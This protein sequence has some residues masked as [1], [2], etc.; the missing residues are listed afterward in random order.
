MALKL[1]P[2][3]RPAQEVFDEF[4]EK[5]PSG[6]YLKLEYNLPHSPDPQPFILTGALEGVPVTCK[7]NGSSTIVIPTSETFPIH[8]QLVEGRNRISVRQSGNTDWSVEVAATNW[9][10]WLLALA[11]E[12]HE[13]ITG[14]LEELQSALLSP[15]GSRLSE[16][17][18][19]YREFLVDQRGKRLFY[20]RMAVNASHNGSGT[21]LGVENLSLALTSVW[22][23][24]RT[25]ELDREEFNPFFQGQLLAGADRWGIEVNLWLPDPAAIGWDVLTSHLQNRDGL[26][27]ELLDQRQTWVR[28]ADGTLTQYRRPATAY[29]A[30]QME[31]FTIPQG[32]FLAVQKSLTRSIQ[33]CPWW[34]FDTDIRYPLGNRSFDDFLYTLDS[35]RA[36]L[37]SN[38]GVDPFGN[39]WLGYSV[40]PHFDGGTLDSSDGVNTVGACGMETGWLTVFS[41][42]ADT[43]AIDATT[44][45]SNVVVTTTPGPAVPTTFLIQP[46]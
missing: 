15:W 37:D 4:L 16:F 46:V 40:N 35:D 14:P 41:E 18:L 10:A 32:P 12:T 31:P 13:A 38:D 39:G 8:L 45:I 34:K 26:E 3:S 20:G 42:I 27:L 6:F 25:L 1:V 17:L 30:K 9:A 24:L 22:P 5:V 28:D 33:F 29:S 23:E 21:K 11:A 7:V 2:A 43:V 44:D 36:T 19:P